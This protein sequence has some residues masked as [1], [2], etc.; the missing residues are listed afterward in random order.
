MWKGCDHRA[1]TPRLAAEATFHR[2]DVPQ[3]VLG[4][5]SRNQLDWGASIER[6]KV[7]ANNGLPCLL[8]I[9]ERDLLIAELRLPHAELLDWKT[10][11]LS[12]PNPRGHFMSASRRN[13]LPR[14]DKFS[15]GLD[16][17]R[18]P[19]SMHHCMAIGT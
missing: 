6:L 7:G 5:A 12:S 18:G 14:L 8:R 1:A 13:P 9:T 11:L 16:V 10:Q 17:H 4:F 19:L 2:F 15:Q 3:D